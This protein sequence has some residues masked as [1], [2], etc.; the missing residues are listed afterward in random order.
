MEGGWGKFAAESGFTRRASESLNP[1]MIVACWSAASRRQI[2]SVACRSGNWQE[3][4]SKGR[5]SEWRGQES[6]SE[7]GVSEH[8]VLH[9]RR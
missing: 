8:K 4:E 1:D 6:E 7:G 9:G 2:S 5:V 3:T